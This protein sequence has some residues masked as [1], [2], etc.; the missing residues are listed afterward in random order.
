[1]FVRRL[2]SEC[3]WLRRRLN[4]FVTLNLDELMETT[5]VMMTAPPCMFGYIIVYGITEEECDEK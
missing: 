2:N 4:L 5:N 1:M 3:S